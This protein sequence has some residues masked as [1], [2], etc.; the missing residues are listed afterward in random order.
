[1][2]AAGSALPLRVVDQLD[3]T[4]IDLTAAT[5][6]A[7]AVSGASLVVSLTLPAVPRLHVPRGAVL[8]DAGTHRSTTDAWRTVDRVCADED[9]IGVLGGSAPGRTCPR[10]VILAHPPGPDRLLHLDI[11][12]AH[13]LTAAALRRGAGALNRIA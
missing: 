13:L 10:E 11:A 9:L 6:P 7:A 1:M 5:T 3:L 2:C 12:L 4:G 8:V